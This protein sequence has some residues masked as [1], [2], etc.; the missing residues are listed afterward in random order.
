MKLLLCCALLVSAAALAYSADRPKITGID[1]VDFYTT[2]PEANRQLY[3]DLL[4]LNAADSI[5]PGQTQRFWVGTQSVGY[6][7]AADTKSNNRR[8]T[9]HSEPMIAKR[10]R[11]T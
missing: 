2:A 9:L 8:T 4:G 11:S 7:P 5:E 1:H 3:T 10:C 6:S